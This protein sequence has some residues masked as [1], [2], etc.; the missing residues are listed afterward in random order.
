MYYVLKKPIITEKNSMI[1]EQSNTYAFEVEQTATK[2]EIKSAVEKFFNVKVKSVN[3][4]ICRNRSTRT[5]MGMSKV[6][7]WK[8][9]M[10]KLADGEK[11]SL[12]EGAN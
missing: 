6:K 10:V 12:F 2:P 3:T 5:K 1:A 9:A 8:K 4:Q 7:Y 11:I